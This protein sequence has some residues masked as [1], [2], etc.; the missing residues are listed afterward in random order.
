[1]KILVLARRRGDVPFEAFQPYVTAEIQAV[2]NLYAQG[3][4]REFYART[5]QPGPA[6]LALECP[7]IEA[8]Q[9]ALATLPMVEL[10][11]LDLELIPLA[12]FI[13]LTHLF[14]PAS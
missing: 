8:A 13:H 14:Q 5:D 12:P 10:G 3:I 1:M 2:W 7:T 4:C 6:V 11:L 9:A